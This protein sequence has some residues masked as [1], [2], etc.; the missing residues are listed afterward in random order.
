M[1]DD[2]FD[3]DTTIAKQWRE[4]VIV[5]LKGQGYRIEIL[6]AETEPERHPMQNGA[7]WLGP[8]PDP[9]VEADGRVGH[10][11]TLMRAQGYGPITVW[12]EALLSTLVGCLDREGYR[13]VKVASHHSGRRADGTERLSQQAR[14]LDTALHGEETGTPWMALLGEV[15]GLRMDCERLAVLKKDGYRVVK[16]RSLKEHL[17]MGVSAWII[18]EEL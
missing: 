12:Q 10:F 11:T 16:I 5:D 18:E 3:P 13:I 17:Y 7:D 6:S 14:E 2:D 1:S 8:E 15:G 9:S 4:R